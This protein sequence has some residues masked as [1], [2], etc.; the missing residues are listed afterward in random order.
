MSISR[1]FLKHTNLPLNLPLKTIGDQLTGP[2]ITLSESLAAVSFSREGVES[3]QWKFI[4]A[5]RASLEVKS[6]SAFNVILE[7]F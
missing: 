2:L 7:D 6:I 1:H 3:R 5:V 4:E